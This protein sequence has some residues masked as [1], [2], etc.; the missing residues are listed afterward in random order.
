MKLEDIVDNQE[1]RMGR[2]FDLFIQFLILVSLVTFSIETLPSLSE[3]TN[4]ILILLERGILA[5]FTLEY[6]LRIVVAR[7]KLSFVFSL[8]G[9]I[10]L[11]AILPSY[12]SLGVLD[13]RSVRIFRFLRLVRAFKLLRYSAAIRRFRHALTLVKEELILFWFMTVIVL[14]LSAV[15]I[16]Y[17]ENE[18]QPE[19]FSSVFHSLWWAVA[20]LTTVGYGDVYPVT[21]G[22]KLFTFFVLMTGLGLVAVPAGLLSSALSS[23]RRIEQE[24]EVEESS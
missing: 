8:F 20:T 15:G 17:F 9:M 24:E 7:R 18:A 2:I 5:V 6:L 10:D 13:L 1:T 22:G 21:I 16:Y 19:I 3:K 23:A 11:L 14:Y 4:R 12:L